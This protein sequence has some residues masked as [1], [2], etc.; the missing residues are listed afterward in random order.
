MT[1]AQVWTL[2]DGLQARMVMYQDVS[3]AMRAAAIAEEAPA[4]D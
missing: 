4:G 2:R 1:F 3:A